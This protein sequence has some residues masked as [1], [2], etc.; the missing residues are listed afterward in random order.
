MRYRHQSVLNWH[1]P[2]LYLFLL[3]SQ[4]LT[5]QNALVLGEEMAGGGAGAGEEVPGGGA[6]WGSLSVLPQPCQGIQVRHLTNYPHIYRHN[7]TDS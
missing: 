7:F 1:Y 5:V 6:P 3:K 4:S 2:P